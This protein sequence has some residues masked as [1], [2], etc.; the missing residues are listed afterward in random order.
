[1]RSV[2]TRT[3]TVNLNKADIEA[4]VRAFALSILTSAERLA[5]IKIE[6]DG[7]EDFDNGGFYL[8]GATVTITEDVTPS[9]PHPDTRESRE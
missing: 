9:S 8:N 7:S 6:W 1:M 5:Q 4:A 3:T 2:T